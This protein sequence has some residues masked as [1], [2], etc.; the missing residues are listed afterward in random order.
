[1]QIYLAV[2]VRKD[3]Y[4][5]SIYNPKIPSIGLFSSA[6]AAVDR[7]LSNLSFSPLS[8]QQHISA[9]IH[10]QM[11]FALIRCCYLLDSINSKKCE[12]PT[13]IFPTFVHNAKNKKFV[14]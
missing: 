3:Q 12:M 13:N 8:C 7:N 4:S 1:M 14:V 2:V 6:C 9:L 11:D 5:M 10:A